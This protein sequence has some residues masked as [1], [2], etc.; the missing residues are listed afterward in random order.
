MQPFN[1]QIDVAQPFQAALSGYQGGL[2]LNGLQAK[3]E[4]QQ[5]EMQQKQAE[6]Q[7]KQQTQN[8]LFELSN[9]PNASGADY[10]RVMTRNPQ[11]S[12]QLGDAWGAMNTAQQQSRLQTGAQAY[13][14][15]QSGRI[16][17]AV[18]MF[19]QQATAAR[20]SGSEAE[21]KQAE[22]MAKLLQT[23]PEVAR[24]SMGLLLS[25]QMG[26]E[27]FAENFAKLNGENRATDLHP[28]EMRQKTATAAGAESD[29]VVKA[30]EAKY[31]PKRV[32]L[33]IEK[34]GAE[35]G[36]TT[37]QIGQ[38]KASAAASYASANS[39]NANAAKTRREMAEGGA[40]R[41]TPDKAMEAEAK[42]RKEYSDQTKGFQE[43][44]E[45]YRRVKSSN[46]DAVGDLSL[47]FG[48]MKML[49]PG[50]VVREGEF[51]TAQNAAGIPDRMRNVYN[52]AVSGERLTPGQRK[53]FTGQAEKLYASAQQQEK[54][55]RTGLE[56]I[57]TGYGIKKENI[58]YDPNNAPED[59]PRQSQQAGASRPSTTG[60]T[61][62]AVEGGYRFKGGDPSKQSSWERAR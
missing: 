12:K 11:L 52:R 35:L 62:G 61:V 25:S 14:A 5:L 13:A 42:L 9:N 51:A 1:Y 50:S 29:A 31:A 21:A 32:P 34:L 53:A 56:R 28:I 15:V 18:D 39:S 24:T 36:L 8:D 47:I 10:A 44:R 17:L 2:A 49:D 41:L 58:F 48:Y 37:A 43:V 22:T 30:E 19:T 38:A 60:P 3:Q 6:M 57:A 7:A 4:A 46:D 33:E 59:A 54:T 45:A 40:G 20:N 27:K 55:V 23:N 26:P 16:D